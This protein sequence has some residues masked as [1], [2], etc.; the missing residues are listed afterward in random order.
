MKL[1]AVSSTK[2]SDLG[3]LELVEKKFKISQLYLK[4]TFFTTLPNREIQN[5][6]LFF[7]ICQ[8]GLGLLE[9]LLLL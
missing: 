2:C 4:I 7:Q 5:S 8:V 3:Q 6:F 1:Q 9:F